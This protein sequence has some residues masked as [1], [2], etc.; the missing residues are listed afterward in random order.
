[1]TFWLSSFQEFDKHATKCVAAMFE[2][3]DR[4]LYDSQKSQ[5]AVL[6]KECTEWAREFVYMRQALIQ[7][8]QTNRQ[9]KTL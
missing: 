6:N 3:I 5:N 9:I 7:F 4:V 2:E 1:M 8:S